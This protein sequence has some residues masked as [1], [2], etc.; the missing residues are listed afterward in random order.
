M[1][2]VLRAPV[3]RSRL[4]LRPITPTV[5]NS[6]AGCQRRRYAVT[7]PGAPRFQVFNRRTKWLQKE[8][9]GANAEEGRQ[10]DYLK[11]EVAMRLADRLLVSTRSVS[12]IPSPGPKEKLLTNALVTRTLTGTFPKFS[13]SAPTRAI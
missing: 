9:A 3:A 12:T 4:P 6:V 8:R 5:S 2:P 10:A 7:S 13:T 1:R 11:D